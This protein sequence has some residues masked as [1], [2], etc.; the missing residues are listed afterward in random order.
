[1]HPL[2]LRRGREM[3][4]GFLSSRRLWVSQYSIHSPK[5]C[6]LISAC[7]TNSTI[8]LKQ[9]QC[10]RMERRGKYEGRKGELV[11]GAPVIH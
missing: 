7:S 2:Y 8:G 11:S 6:N 3:H 4:C 9:G 5:G 10:L 1:M